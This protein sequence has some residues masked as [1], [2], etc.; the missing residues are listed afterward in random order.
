MCLW[1]K[2]FNIDFSSWLKCPTD[3]TWIRIPLR[4]PCSLIS[5]I[6]IWYHSS[7]VLTSVTSPCN[8]WQV[9]WLRSGC[10]HPLSHPVSSPVWASWPEDVTRISGEKHLCRNFCIDCPPCG[11]TLHYS[12]HTRASPAVH[13]IR[14][15]CCIH[16]SSRFIIHHRAERKCPALIFI[17]PG[18]A[19]PG[20]QNWWKD[21]CLLQTG[22]REWHGS[23][24]SCSLF[25][26]CYICYM[27][28]SYIMD[29][30]IVF[31]YFKIV[32]E[33]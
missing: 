18:P 3:R 16:N 10:A 26:S 22:N 15:A 30:Q 31:G 20:E 29:R 21:L 4:I 2:Q 25:T 23:H 14:I 27:L 33:H 17:R 32:R 12:Q 11:M 5:G 24:P 19:F 9:T 6:P 13:C 28:Q 7:W 1:S 8:P